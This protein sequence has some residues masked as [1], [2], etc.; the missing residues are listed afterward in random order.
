MLE[1]F[2]NYLKFYG[3]AKNPCIWDKQQG[4]LTHLKQTLNEWCGVK[5][6]NTS[7]SM[8]FFLKEA[9]EEESISE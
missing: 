5:R 8:S 7:K 4:D 9:G 2:S 1:M 3:R 6:G